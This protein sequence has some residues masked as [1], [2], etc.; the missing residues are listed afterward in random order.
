VGL[1]DASRAD[2]L[3]LGELAQAAEE[4]GAC[5]VR[6]ADTLGVLDPFSTF[7][8]ISQLRSQLRIDI[9]IHAHND[10]GLATANT[11]A[12]LRAGAT[13]ANTTVNGLGERAGNAALEEVVMGLRHLHGLDVGVDTA[14][15]CGLSALVARASG[16][17]VA[18]NKSIVGEAVFTHEAGIHVDGLNKH[19]HT[20]EGFDP[21]ELGRQRRT[22]LG[23]HSG[24]RAVQIACTALGLDTPAVQLQALLDRVRLHAVLTKRSPNS[25][26]LRRFW[27][28]THIDLG[29]AA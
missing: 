22:V 1:E 23:K 21:S 2:P 3:W 12:A 8:L 7:K 20:Y 19:P 24:T 25:D 18:A 28:E 14:A 4:A 5:R 13:H 6:V 29:C 10:L 11:L 17:P 15:L 26:D 27:H 16:R 9:E